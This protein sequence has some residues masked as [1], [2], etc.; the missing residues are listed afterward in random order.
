MATEINWDAP[1]EAVHEDG[2]VVA[3][4]L[5]KYEFEPDG[6]DTRR[7]E[8]AVELYS[9]W[10]H[11]D[12][13]RWDGG[14]TIRNVAPTPTPMEFGPEIK[15]DGIRPEW[16]KDGDVWQWKLDDSEWIDA[17][18]SPDMYEWKVTDMDAIRLPANHPH[19][20]TPTPDERAVAP[21]L[22][23]RLVGLAE[24]LAKQS[25]GPWPCQDEARAIVAALE[26]VDSDK[27]EAM[28]VMEGYCTMTDERDRVI[29]NKKEL[30]DFLVASLRR[31][32]QLEKEGK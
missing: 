2:R 12:G 21:E 23:S 32:R 17:N 5:V 6:K 4:T 25:M 19:Y 20:N 11:E 13:T 8:P 9:N 7:V 15:V 22:V 24:R 29:I 30:E 28:S 14:W 10:F 18:Y 16:L 3:V 1:I 27:E 31:G 26:P